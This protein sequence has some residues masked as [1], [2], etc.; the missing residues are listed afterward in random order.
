MNETEAVIFILAWSSPF[1]VSAGIGTLIMWAYRWRKAIAEID[2]WKEAV[3]LVMSVMPAAVFK[4][5]EPD[6]TWQ[7]VVVAVVTSVMLFVK[8]NSAAVPTPG[9]KPAEGQGK[10]TTAMLVL[11]VLVVG[12]CCTTGYDF[13]VA[14]EE[15]E[16]L[17]CEQLPEPQ[18]DP[19]VQKV[20]AKYDPIFYSMTG[21]TER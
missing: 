1:L 3:G 9:S 8:S 2:T 12:G 5:T 18:I 4:M 6:V 11:L 21:E 15:Q 7:A 19:C 10:A 20:G 14:R 13:L 16:I 17:D